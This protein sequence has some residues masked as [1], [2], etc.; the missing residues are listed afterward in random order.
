MGGR[1]S[2]V[3]AAR[4]RNGGSA[5]P[6]TGGAR[7]RGLDEAGA[8]TL[9]D[10]LRARAEVE[11]GWNP[12][13]AVPD[14]VRAQIDERADLLLVRPPAACRMMVTSPSDR[15]APGLPLVGGVGDHAR[16]DLRVEAFLKACGAKVLEA[17][18][19]AG[20]LLALRDSRST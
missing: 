11:G 6:R 5:D 1:R 12:L 19:A 17:R 14:R 3:A 2:R 13:Q 8:K 18:S 15:L 7:W 10:D 9:G 4:R 20:A 16:A